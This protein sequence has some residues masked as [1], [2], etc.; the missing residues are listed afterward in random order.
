MM[1]DKMK[2]EPGPH[3]SHSH[4]QCIC[5]GACLCIA[6][7][8]ESTAQHSAP[9]CP[10]DSGGRTTSGGAGEGEHSGVSIQFRVQLEVDVTWDNN[11]TYIEAQQGYRV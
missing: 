10:G 1:N 4:P 3:L 9:P 6:H 5:V 7:Y 2:R 8:L 11:G